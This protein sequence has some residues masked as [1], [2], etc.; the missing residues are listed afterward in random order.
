M[1][2][3]KT[4]ADAATA[5]ILAFG[6]LVPDL[7]YHVV[8]TGAYNTATDSLSTTDVAVTCKGVVYKDKVTSNDFKKTHLSQKKVLIAAQALPGVVPKDTHY[9][10]IKGVKNEIKDVISVPGD[11]IFI[12]VVREP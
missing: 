8:T 10:M 3:S 9:I 5:A 11:P 7:E 4:L 2:L 1:G 12:F 6:D